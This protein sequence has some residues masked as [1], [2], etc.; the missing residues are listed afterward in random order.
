MVKPSTIISE[1]NDMHAFMSKNKYKQTGWNSIQ[2]CYAALVFFFVGAM[3]TSCEQ[4]LYYII[5]LL[6]RKDT[7]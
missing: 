2:L 1:E 4:G 7:Q 3:R 6:L 5:A